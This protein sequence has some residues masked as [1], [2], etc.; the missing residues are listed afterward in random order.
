MQ[1]A[2]EIEVDE[3]S[4]IWRTD[5]LP[6]VYVPR[7]F[8]VNMHREIETTLGRETYAA[9]LD[10]S[11][12][13]SARHWC[14]RQADLLGTDER[15]VFEHY[16]RRLSERGWGRFTIEA[17]DLER[18]TAEIT[19]RDSIYVLES[20]GAA[21]APVCYIFEG[22]LIGAMQFICD[23]QGVTPGEITCRETQCAAM[24]ATECRFELSCHPAA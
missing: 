8:M 17:L 23:A 2:V 3:A 13:K 14:Q 4:G 1:P 18:L 21:K 22:F 24:G 9:V 16:L 11:G 5:G 12:A 19:L 15:E 7:H 6:M 10:R 20:D